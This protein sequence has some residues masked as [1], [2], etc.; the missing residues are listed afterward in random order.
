[1]YTFLN[2]GLGMSPGKLAAQASHAA[3][4]AYRISS[5]KMVDAWY[6]GKHYT[7]LIMLAEDAEQLS[8]IQTYIEA[9]GFRTSLIID[10]GR[11]EIPPF[12]KTAL[13]VEIVDKDDEHVLATFGEFQVY[14]ELPKLPEPSQ[15]GNWRQWRWGKHT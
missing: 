8:T 11:T 6:C 13:G 4:E 2:R 12:S 14:K 5:P 7:K 9:R 1:M 15:D 10:E 3:V